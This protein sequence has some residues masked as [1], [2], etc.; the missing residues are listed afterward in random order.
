MEVVSSILDENGCTHLA[1]SVRGYCSLSRQGDGT[2]GSVRARSQTVSNIAVCSFHSFYYML[3]ENLYLTL[4]LGLIRM[5]TFFQERIDRCIRDQQEIERLGSYKPH[6]GGIGKAVAKYSPELFERIIN[7]EELRGVMKHLHYQ[8]LLEKP[9]EE[10]STLTPLPNYAIEYT[11]AWVGTGQ[12]KVVLLNN[13]NLARTQNEETRWRK[14]KIEL[15][16]ID[17]K[18]NCAECIAEREERAQ[19]ERE[20]EEKKLKEEAKGDDG[21]EETKGEGNEAEEKM[22][23]A[24]VEGEDEEVELK[25][26]EEKKV[27]K[28]VAADEEKTTEETTE[29]LAREEKS[30]GEKD[31]DIDDAEFQEFLNQLKEYS[32]K[33]VV[34]SK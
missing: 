8:E 32:V 4:L 22:V 5:G 16:L 26:P 10:W 33:D 12:Q 24:E 17:E 11:P 18:C 21:K 19:M 9:P 15:G 14:I 27:E 2:G 34:G 20:A 28:A 7:D 31:S 6:S 30:K 1:D 13:G 23:E 25:D 3:I 29:M